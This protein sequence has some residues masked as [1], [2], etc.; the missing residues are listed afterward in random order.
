MKCFCYW[1]HVTEIKKKRKHVFMPLKR[2]EVTKTS[3]QFAHLQSYWN[4]EKKNTKGTAEAVCIL[5]HYENAPKQIYWK[6]YHQIKHE[7]L[8]INILIVF[9]I[10][11]QT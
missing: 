1:T 3:V 4:L 7:N 5:Q 11:L 6:K 10:P 9:I 8:L 2:S